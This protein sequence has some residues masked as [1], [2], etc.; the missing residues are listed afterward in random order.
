ML[1]FLNG[2]KISDRIST[3]SILIKFN[4][5]SVNQLNAQIKIMEIWKAI[6]LTMTI[7]STSSTN[8]SK[9]LEIRVR[10]STQSK[11]QKSN[12]G[13]KPYNKILDNI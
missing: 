4:I 13:L 7:R 6:K 11:M 9:E 3:E 10:I 12:T 2:S 5:L 8:N 1:R